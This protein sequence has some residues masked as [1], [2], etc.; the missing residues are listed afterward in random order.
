MT[1]QGT[2]SLEPAD[3]PESP[4][5][6]DDDGSADEAGDTREATDADRTLARFG[7]GGQLSIGEF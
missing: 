5:A 7:A 4:F 1:T 3:D 2:L 6:D